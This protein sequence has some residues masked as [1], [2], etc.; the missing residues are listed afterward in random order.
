LDEAVI[1]GRS[2]RTIVTELEPVQK[3]RQGQFD[4]A[5]KRKSRG[6]RVVQMGEPYLLL[7]AELDEALI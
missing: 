1:A 6:M 7:D 4:N 3:I 2:L 5:N